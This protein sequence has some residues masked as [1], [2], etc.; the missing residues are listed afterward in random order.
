MDESPLHKKFQF[1]E[2]LKEST[3]FI[4]T[5]R[6]LKLCL[7]LNLIYVIGTLMVFFLSDFFLL[8]HDFRI[9]GQSSKILLD[10]P[11]DLY[12]STDYRYPFRYF[13]LFSFLNIPMSFLPF[14]V[15]FVIHTI[16][17]ETVH[18]GSFYL[19]LILCKKFYHLDL[20][21]W[22]EMQYL[23]L[24]LA[25]PLQVP[26]L[27]I[28]QISEIYIFLVLLAVLF[29]E[30][31][32]NPRYEHKFN[33]FFAGVMLGLSMIY[34]P[35]SIL[36]L[37]FLFPIYLNLNKK[38]FS[39]DFKAIIHAITGFL[40]P[41]SP[42]LYYWIKYPN[43]L[44]DFFAIN[45]SAQILDYPSTS[46]TRIITSIFAM[47]GIR[48]SEFWFM[49][50][51]V[52]F[53]FGMI[54]LYYILQIPEDR[55]FSVYFG[56]AMLILMISYPD[57]WFLYFLIWYMITVPGLLKYRYIL[58]KYRGD[59]QD[60]SFSQII[61]YVVSNYG[62]IYFTIGI[63]Q[64]LFITK[65]VFQPYSIDLIQP[66]SLILLAIALYMQNFRVN[67]HLL[68]NEKKSKPF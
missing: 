55:N 53:L 54:F 25:A 44:P 38:H 20:S 26:N 52:L 16:L 27:I 1:L 31:A 14:S 51:I 34:K 5:S 57:S 2:D 50:V 47:I 18:I 19:I 6:P 64:A 60:K 33:F 11:T 13:P 22:R 45:A 40:L 30:N 36:L 15:G 29:L 4:R 59:S 48:F 37:P 10:N 7:L 56:F 24:A 66:I 63:I 8:A 9:F 35:F 39:I 23:I 32:K 21:T 62:I 17:M 28:G 67:K 65:N 41:I 3:E 58:Q 68:H 61:I 43:Y 46:I 49:V 42:N 12:T